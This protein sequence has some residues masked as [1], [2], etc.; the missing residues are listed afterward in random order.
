MMPFIEDG[1]DRARRPP[2]SPT[3]I[4]TCRSG[5]HRFS[6]TP[7]EAITLIADIG[8]EGD[9][10]SGA[11]VKHRSR[12]RRN[13]LQPNLRQ[14]HLIAS[15]LFDEVAEAGFTVR[16]GDMGENVTTE[17]I[18]LIRL[19]KGTR[20]WLGDEAAVEIT[21]LR[22]PCA[23]IDGFQEGLLAQMVSK[24]EAGT[25]IRKAGVMSIVI[26]GG[27]VRP[28]D[29]IRVTLPPEPHVALERV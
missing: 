16:P 2:V 17:G 14:V 9:A 7:R 13:P 6:K 3:V 23:Q 22:N 21:G 19:P 27:V 5:E 25:I 10:H 29:A 8:V 24:D 26:R 28:G 11:L 20:L 12:V 1:S 15:E 4:A 18:D